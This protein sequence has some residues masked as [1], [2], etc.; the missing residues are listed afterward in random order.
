V[1]L[2][3]DAGLYGAAREGLAIIYPMIYALFSAVRKESVV[4]IEAIT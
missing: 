2:T 3:L 1:R 4:A